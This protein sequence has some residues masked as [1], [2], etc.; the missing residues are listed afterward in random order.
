MSW[1]Q[2]LYQTYEASMGA[3]GAINN[4]NGKERDVLLPVG[5]T[6]LR[7]SVQVNLAADGSFVSASRDKGHGLLVC[8]PCTE[9]SESR[10]GNSSPHALFDQLKYIAGDY[11]E[12]TGVPN[13]KFFN[14]YIQNLGAWQASKHSHPK[15]EAIYAYLEKRTIL[16][17]LVDAEV[18][19]TDELKAREEKNPEKPVLEKVCVRFR[20]VNA[21][22]LNDG[23]ER[24]WLNKDI[25]NA[26]LNYQSSLLAQSEP[27]I[28]YVSG[29]MLVPAVTHP[30]K[31]DT[32]NA[33][34]KLISTCAEQND[35]QNFVYRG[36]FEN[37]LQ[38]Y[39]VSY[40]VS[41]KAHQA[42]RWLIAKQGHQCDTQII[43]AWAI[44]DTP[45]IISYREASK[46]DLEK[47]AAVENIVCTDYANHLR[48]NLA[49]YGNPNK[50]KK[51]ARRIAVLVLNVTTP[52]RRAVTYYR[53][54]AEDEY[55]ERII[56]W[57][58]T[59]KWYQV[60]TKNNKDGKPETGY[61]V[62]AP[63]F[64]Q[65]AEAVLGNQKKD[66]T[67]Y[68]QL[69]KGIQAQL[70]RC[71]FDAERIPREMVNATVRRAS[72]PLALERSN[73]N[74]FNERW[75]DWEQVLG[76]ACSLVRRYNYDYKKEEIGL[77][78]ERQKRDREYLYGR[79]LAMAD[80]IELHARYKQGNLKDRPRATNAMR[81]MT[82]FAQR[83]FKTWNQ[84]FDQK[85]VPYIKILKGADWYLHQIKEIKSLFKE[86]EFE[87][88]ASLD[89]KYL[90]GFFAQ[91]QALNLK[92]KSKLNKNNKNNGG[93]DNELNKQN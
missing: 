44:G 48:K 89:G 2:N 90:L 76:T 29:K 43:V 24:V 93:N 51:H 11:A 69:K 23:E 56:Q 25:W 87:S 21:N 27:D 50:L 53:E 42:L 32:K 12:F 30:K 60:F 13:D 59:C 74:N 73:T 3:I 65:I 41:Q 45:E 16:R 37:A 80:K 22:N 84:L 9:G 82:I 83:P 4:V 34:A 38:A 26:H 40:E 58:D 14:A 64:E 19:T 67:T 55:L 1:M 63:S 18:F 85:L 35:K 52:G 47:L 68:E 61:F 71:I 57:H 20:V 54:L 6:L 7:T 33:N 39:A 75:L 5:H 10:T 17:D 66:N 79:L 70:L 91:K 88:N 92:Q 62:G 31:I 81:Y 36:R 28:C 86:G 72:N 46:T 78:L 77:G 49:G 15:I 8:A